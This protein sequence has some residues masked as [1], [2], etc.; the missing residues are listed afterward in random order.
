MK[1]NEDL[2]S[3]NQYAVLVDFVHHLAYYRVLSR[4]YNNSQIRSEYWTRTIDTHLLKA[5]IDWCM[6]FGTNSNEIHW[7][8]VVIDEQ[9][10][11]DFRCHKNK[12]ANMTENQMSKFW[13]GMTNFRNKYAAHRTAA[14]Q[15]PAVPYMDTALIVATSYDDWFRLK[16]EASFAE[17]SLNKRYERLLRTSEKFFK[18][19]ISCGPTIDQEYEGRPP[20]RT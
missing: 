19:L 12:L 1:I 9:Y 18:E 3:Q 5:N 8:K 17:P 20:E 4:F 7:T 6:V 11:C 10:Q 15:F 16:V 2:W 13:S 14:T